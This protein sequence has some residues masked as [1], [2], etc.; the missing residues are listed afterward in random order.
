MI[1]K[2]ENYK[3]IGKFWLKMQVNQNFKNHACQN[4]V[5]METTNCL[6][7]ELSYQIVAR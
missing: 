4:M 7:Q 3:Q 1:W 6:D 5:A 2:C